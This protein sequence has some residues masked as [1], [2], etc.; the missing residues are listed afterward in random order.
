MADPPART[1]KQATS[2][3]TERR[4]VPVAGRVFE[5][6]DIR[7]LAR[8]LERCLHDKDD[9][10]VL[11]VELHGT[12]GDSYQG[13]RASLLEPDDYLVA[14][15][16]E[17]VELM[18]HGNDCTVALELRHGD[19]SLSYHNAL[20]VSGNDATWVNGTVRRMEDELN[21][22]PPQFVWKPVWR[23]LAVFLI[24]LA[25]CAAGVAVG[26]LI[27]Q[28]EPRREPLAAEPWTDLLPRTLGLAMGV[29]AVG[30]SWPGA[31]WIVETLNEMWPSIELRTGR[32]FMSVEVRRRRRAC[33]VAMS[34][35][36]PFVLSVAATVATEF[37][38][39]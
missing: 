15:R 10:A 27:A 19:N 8:N 36:V 17:R 37:L 38:R 11:R 2:L 24:G 18:G 21:R 5:P 22:T 25:G 9:S 4:N 31:A 20:T 34:I 39:E 16:I 35:V 29:F 30:F 13:T 14:R 26:F 33:F 6:E 3:P 28:F 7:R 32:S 1:E 23:Y 12:E